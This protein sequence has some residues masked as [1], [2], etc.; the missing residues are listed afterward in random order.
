[1]SNGRNIA[2]GHFR[3]AVRSGMPACTPNSRPHRGAGDHLSRLGRVAVAADDDGQA[4]EF[5]VAPHFNRGLELV[6]VDVQHPARSS[7]AELARQ[8][9]PLVAQGFERFATVGELM[10]NVVGVEQGQ[11]RV[12]LRVEV[13]GGAGRVPAA[14]GHACAAA[15]PERCSGS[16]DRGWPTRAV[17]GGCGRTTASRPN[18]SSRSSGGASGP[19]GGGPNRKA[20]WLAPLVLVE[21]H[22]HQAGAAAEPAEQRALAH[23]GGRGD[24]VHR[25]RV[26]T[27]LGDEPT[28]GIQQ[29]RPVA[30]RVARS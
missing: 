9:L 2:S 25:H 20:S 30:G 17:R 21:Q 4:L 1:M 3:A 29:Q 5:G 13:A 24:I 22:H 19:S 23:T 27:P 18:A 8:A 12:G 14:D 16:A 6:Q 26:G 10:V 11:Q 15:W 7:A 28:G